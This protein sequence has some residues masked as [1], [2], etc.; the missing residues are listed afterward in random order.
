M[1]G[2]TRL[3]AACASAALI[4]SVGCGTDASTG[5]SLTPVEDRDLQSD[6]SGHA[7]GGHP[8]T[9]RFVQDLDAVF[10]A[11]EF[12]PSFA[13]QVEGE[14]RVTVQVFDTHIVFKFNYK[15]TVTNLATGFSFD[16]NGAW[17]DIF[18][19]DGEGNPETITT[20]GSIFRIVIPG[21]GIVA[22]D[23]GII[24]FD[25][26]TGEI[27]FEGGP[28]EAAHGLFDYCTLLSGS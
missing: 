18:H 19:L 2:E 7:A 26:A 23:T 12:C 8:E 11:G 6:Q 15:S 10:P 20:I 4:L 25:A 17:K 5:P 14:N 13:V 22:Q 9:F 24:T 27:L 3:L 28:H 16:D 1:P 21:Q